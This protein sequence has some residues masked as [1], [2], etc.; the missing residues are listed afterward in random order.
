[1]PYRF[2]TESQNYEDYASGHVFYGLPGH[3][4]FPIRL[5]TEMFQRGLDILRGRGLTGPVTLF[6]PCCG[7]AYHLSTLA[8]LHWSDIGTMFAS[9]IDQ[10]IL[11]VAARNLGLLTSAGLEQ[12]RQEIST[13][14]SQYGKPSHASALESATRLSHTLERNS[15]DHRVETI[16]FAANATQSETLVRELKGQ[17][18]DLVFS[19]VPYGRRSTWQETGDAHDSALW[20][21]LEAM[22]PVLHEQTVV[23]L[24]VDKQQKCKHARYKQLERFKM[25]KRQVYLLQP[26]GM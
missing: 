1:M 23:A 7:G 13:L 17:K 18:I 22:W 8:F 4:A 25:G 2:A 3:P 6:D 16:L 19:D 9:D 24:A 10:D 11:A 20:Q 21:M 26:L 5:T 12:R 15:A 14:L